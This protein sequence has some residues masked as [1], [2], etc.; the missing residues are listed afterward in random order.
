VFIIELQIK[1]KATAG[2]ETTITVPDE[3]VIIT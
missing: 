3:P 1:I 2:S